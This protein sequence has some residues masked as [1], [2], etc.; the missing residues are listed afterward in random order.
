MVNKN[1]VFFFVH[2]KLI[3]ESTKIFE[4]DRTPL[5]SNKQIKKIEV[6]YKNKNKNKIFEL[7]KLVWGKKLKH[8]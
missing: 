4:V 3:F 5:T 1:K 2:T 7:I 6:I 8:T